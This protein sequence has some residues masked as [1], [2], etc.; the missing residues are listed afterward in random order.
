M[1]M[2]GGE[3]RNL[4]VA[5]IQL[6]NGQEIDELCGHKICLLFFAGGDCPVNGG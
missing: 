1:K 4:A 2:V 6:G 5:D 3:Q